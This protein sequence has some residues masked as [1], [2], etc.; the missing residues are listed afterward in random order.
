VSETQSRDSDTEGMGKTKEGEGN[1]EV[2]TYVTAIEPEDEPS[3]H[4]V[5]A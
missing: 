4:L 1:V 3:L 2:K 5:Q